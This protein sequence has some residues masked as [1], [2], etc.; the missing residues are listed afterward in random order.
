LYVQLRIAVATSSR[1][2]RRQKAVS[3]L[4]PIQ[5][6]EEERKNSDKTCK[7]TPDIYRRFQ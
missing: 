4:K 3:R 6:E 5:E 7:A 2:H 1:K